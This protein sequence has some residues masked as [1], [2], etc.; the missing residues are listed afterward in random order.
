MTH[1]ENHSA[2]KKKS[3]VRGKCHFCN[4]DVLDTQHRS[5]FGS[6]SHSAYG[7]YFHTECN[8]T[9]TEHEVCDA[10]NKKD[11]LSMSI[12]DLASEINIT[13]EEVVRRNEACEACFY[14]RES[15]NQHCCQHNEDCIKTQVYK[16]CEHAEACGNDEKA[17]KTLKAFIEFANETTLRYNS[18]QKFEI[19]EFRKASVYE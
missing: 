12:E 6:V 4:E 17:N 9:K 8:Q 15:H 2:K 7:I 1:Q 16:M 11:T 14:E 18:N 3:S 13:R 5:K 10:L 19:L